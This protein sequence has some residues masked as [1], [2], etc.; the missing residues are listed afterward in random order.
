[1][2]TSGSKVLFETRA[3]EKSIE[4]NRMV[5][6]VP[7]GY[8]CLSRYENDRTRT[9]QGS[10]VADG[11]RGPALFQYEDLL[12][13]VMHVKGNDGPRFQTFCDRNAV[14]GPAILLIN[15]NDEFRNGPGAAASVC[16]P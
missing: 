2:D 12:G 10:L 8:P 15:L 5:S 9:S 11:Y 16:S 1:M 6:G 3:R 4:V 13:V 7:Y 14:F